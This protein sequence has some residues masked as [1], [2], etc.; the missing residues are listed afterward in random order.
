M[1]KPGR[2]IARYWSL[3]AAG[4][5]LVFG[6]TAGALIGQWLDH[7]LGTSPWLTAGGVALGFVFGM[8]ALFAAVGRE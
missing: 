4:G 7:H 5:E 6:V 8:W 2:R 3:A 1:D